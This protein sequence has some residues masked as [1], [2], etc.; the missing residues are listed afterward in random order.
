MLPR[1]VLCIVFRI[2]QKVT[3]TKSLQSSSKTEAHSFP[4]LYGTYSQ[5]C[6]SWE[7]CISSTQRVYYKKRWIK[8]SCKVTCCRK[9]SLSGE[10]TI[11]VSG[12]NW[13][14]RNFKEIEPGC[15]QKQYGQEFHNRVYCFVSLFAII[16]RY[17]GYASFLTPS[18]CNKELWE[19]LAKPR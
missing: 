7:G 19:T 18:P 16:V 4:F 6:G 9:K 8:H 17:I 15:Q 12:K 1:F 14:E 11:N 3:S 5:V 2:V 13:K 10:N